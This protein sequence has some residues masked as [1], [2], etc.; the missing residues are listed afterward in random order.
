MYVFQGI[1]FIWYLVCISA[2]ILGSQQAI[3]TFYPQLKVEFSLLT[4]GLSLFWWWRSH[5]CQGNRYI[6]QWSDLTPGFVLRDQYCGW[7]W[8]WNLGLP[9][10][11]QVI[12]PS[13]LSFAPLGLI[14]ITASFSYLRYVNQFPFSEVLSFQRTLP[15]STPIIHGFHSFFMWM[16]TLFH[17]LEFKLNTCAPPA[18]SCVKMLTRSQ[19]SGNRALED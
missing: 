19:A 17:L 1:L 5:H 4:L 16:N 12:Y 13:D 10:A 6:Q 8:G 9:C 7:I 18:N 2:W 15:C 14:L 11:S 3:L